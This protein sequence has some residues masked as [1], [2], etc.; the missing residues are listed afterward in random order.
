MTEALRT[1]AALASDYLN[2]RG[3]YIE[4]LKAILA[5][6]SRAQA[7]RQRGDCDALMDAMNELRI[8]C[9]GEHATT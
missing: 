1:P 5:D 3:S 8:M 6:M 2:K 9:S 4:A 7:S